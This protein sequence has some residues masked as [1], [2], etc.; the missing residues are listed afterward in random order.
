MIWIQMVA[1]ERNSNPYLLEHNNALIVAYCN[2]FQRIQSMIS[3]L[4]EKI[5]LP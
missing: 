1:L 4:A 5:Q 3:K 2:M